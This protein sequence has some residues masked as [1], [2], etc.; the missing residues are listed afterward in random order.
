M[1]V[2]SDFDL[3]KKLFPSAKAIVNQATAGTPKTSQVRGTAVSDSEDGTVSVVLDTMAGG[4]DAVME[5]PT[6]GGIT[7]GSEVL[8]TLLDG[9]PVDCAQAG[10]ID[11][12]QAVADAIN[13]HFWHDENGAHVTQATQDEWEQEQTGPNALWNSLGMLFRDGL[14]NLLAVLTNGITIYD[15]EGNA[16]TNLIA[17]ITG[18]IIR[19]GRH[20]ADEVGTS[21]AT[22]QFFDGDWFRNNVNAMVTVGDEE[23]PHKQIHLD[24]TTM[25]EDATFPGTKAYIDAGV[26]VNADSYDDGGSH[27]ETTSASLS[28]QT[29]GRYAYTSMGVRINESYVGTEKVSEYR[30][31]YVNADE[32]QIK[33]GTGQDAQVRVVSM[34]VASVALRNPVA[35]YTGTSGTTAATATGWR[36]TY[37]NVVRATHGDP[38]TY[39]YTFSNGV[40]TALRDC[41]LEISGVMHWQDG[42][43]GQRGFG[44]FESGTA[45]SGTE[46][47]AFESWTGTTSG[48]KSVVFPPQVFV[49]NQTGQLTFGRYDTTGA[50]YTNGANF[51]WVTI[52]VIG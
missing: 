31:V 19:L 6:S 43:A 40:I 22:M 9:T 10:S 1:A 48:H 34:E 15:G 24:L 28:A 4:E 25:I 41:V 11:S 50:V 13:Q 30:Q 3:A 18:D 44:V 42:V 8:V 33:Y 51:S 27:A 29:S 38:H 14:T 46:H 49:L 12:V 47:S 2:I 17:E 39:D 37:F 45:G 7:E 52:R 5:V 35:T 26:N 23:D 21:T 32:L 20:I 36:L 16:D